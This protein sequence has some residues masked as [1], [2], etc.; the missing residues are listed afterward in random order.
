MRPRS[1][2]RGSNPL[3]RWAAAAAGLFFLIVAVASIGDVVV[4]SQQASGDCAPAPPG[5]GELHGVP[6]RL[7]ALYV[8]G[9]ERYR[10][11]AR[12]PGVL[13]A[14]NFVE[15]DFGHN[16]G[17]SSAGAEGWMQFLP[18]SWRSYGVDAD[19]DGRADPYDPADAIYAA[20]KLL[21]ASGAPND[22]Y[23]A[24]FAYNHADWYVQ[25]VFRYAKV[26]SGIA[27]T[28][29]SPGSCR[30]ATGSGAYVNPLGS[31][32]EW[33]PE[34]TDMGVDYAP[35]RPSVPV[36]AIGDAKVLGSTTSSSWPGGAFIWY[37]LLDGDHEGAIV[38]VAET[39]S[40]LALANTTVKAGDRIAVAHTGGTG[41]ETGWARASG[42]ARAAPC[43]SEGMDTNSGKEF[44]RFM[45]ALGA[46][47]EMDP[48]PGPD[49][50]TGPLC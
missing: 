32:A 42:Q 19:G 15:T 41:I 20:A 14:I 3:A 8:G 6:R 2:R 29:P 33:L 35:L 27:Q 48:G 11:G 22:W 23:G 7:V 26:F 24:V 30:G 37:R 44:T 31:K 46:N 17:T 40:D 49:Y 12:G 25:R 5:G 13:A 45:K 47:V 28:P 10:L 18:S 1:R 43:Y 4:L 9:A 36:L 34:R 39:L 50:P 21:R 16:L 38:Y